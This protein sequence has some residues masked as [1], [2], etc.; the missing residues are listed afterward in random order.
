[1]LSPGFAMVQKKP[2]NDGSSAPHERFTSAS[3]GF[4]VFVLSGLRK[5]M[6]MAPT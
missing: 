1:M 2:K 5:H 3:E 4:I 6:R